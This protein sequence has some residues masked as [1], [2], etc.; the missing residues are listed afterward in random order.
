MKKFKTKVYQYIAN[1][2]C[3]LMKLS[4]KMDNEELF[5]R[6]MFWGVYLDVTCV[7]QDIYLD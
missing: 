7:H 6:L 5:E 3:D 2:I 1:Q 4:I